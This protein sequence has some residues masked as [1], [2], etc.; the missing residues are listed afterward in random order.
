MNALRIAVT[1]VVVTL[2]S[3]CGAAP[4]PVPPPSP[5]PA[6]P[7]APSAAARYAALPDTT[8]C[9]VDRTTSR[10]LRDLP[11]KRSEAGGAVVLMGG[12]IQP[13][14]V[15]HPTNVI[16]GYA[17]QETWFTRG[18]SVTVQNRAF[19]RHGGERRVPLDQLTRVG[20]FQGIPV[21]ASPTDP[22]PPPALYVP[23]R[24]GCIFQAY[25]R[26]ELFGG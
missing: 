10:G 11:A 26:Q 13:I 21:Y 1:A 6:A 2:V 20:E 16:A 24:V 4:P 14:E 12:E 22:S 3:G 25:V 5:G 19:V 18:Q 15:L 23:I 9:V 17:G 8:V 7:A